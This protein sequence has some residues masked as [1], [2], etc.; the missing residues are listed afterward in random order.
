MVHDKTPIPKQQFVFFFLV[1]EH[2]EGKIRA[3]IDHNLFFDIAFQSERF[4][5]L[6]YSILTNSCINM[7]LI[8]YKKYEM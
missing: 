7:A 8:N 3:N 2:M 6:L 4:D 5:T 1:G